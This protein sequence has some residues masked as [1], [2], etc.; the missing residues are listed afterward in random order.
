M[1]DLC[2]THN[3]YAEILEIKFKGKSQWPINNKKEMK[4]G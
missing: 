4:M 1:H 3:Y 2:A